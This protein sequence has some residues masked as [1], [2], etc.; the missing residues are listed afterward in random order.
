ML[1]VIAVR[2]VAADFMQLRCPAQFAQRPVPLGALSVLGCRIELPVQRRCD[3]SD[4]ARVRGIDLE[5]AGQ[6]LHRGVAQIAGG[7][8]LTQHV[9]DQ[10][11]A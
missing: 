10:T 9:A 2:N 4:A 7:I 6:T 8:T 11:V 5:F 3:L 1:V